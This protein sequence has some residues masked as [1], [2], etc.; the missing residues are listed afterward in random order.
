MMQA[1]G[2]RAALVLTGY[3]RGDWQLARAESAPAPD[4]IAD[5]VL[6]AVESLASILHPLTPPSVAC[7][8][9]P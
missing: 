1:L 6:A 2:G 5:D 8:S 4:W 7:P 3:G 9:Q